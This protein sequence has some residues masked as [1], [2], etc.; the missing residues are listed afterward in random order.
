M[1]VRAAGEVVRRHDV[2]GPKLDDE[3]DQ[4]GDEPVER[5]GRLALARGEFRQRVVG[6]MQDRVRVEEYQSF[7]ILF[8]H[9]S[10]VYSGLLVIEIYRSASV[11]SSAENFKTTS[12]VGSA[13]S[14][15]SG[16]SMH[17]RLCGSF[18]NVS[19]FSAANSSVF[20]K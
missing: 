5:T 7:F 15:R 2:V 4:H 9:V 13:P 20:S 18:R 1:A 12:G 8:F 6:A 16:H 10:R 17:T 14:S 11:A 19:G 3:F